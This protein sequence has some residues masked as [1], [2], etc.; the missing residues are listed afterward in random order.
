M[1]IA[2]HFLIACSKAFPYPWWYP[3]M[4]TQVDNLYSIKADYYCWSDLHP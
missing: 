2:V 4:A 1:E 3:A